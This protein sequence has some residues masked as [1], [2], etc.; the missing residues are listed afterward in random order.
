MTNV[1]LPERCSEVE[2]LATP[3]GQ[4]AIEPVKKLRGQ[5]TVIAIPAM[6]RKTCTMSYQAG[7]SVSSAVA[8]P[9]AFPKPFIASTST[10]K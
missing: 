3:H 2:Y 1:R 9:N 8:H 4:S 6:G 5:L 10:Y 7:G